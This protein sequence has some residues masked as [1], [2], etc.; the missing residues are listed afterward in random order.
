MFELVT[1]LLGERTS[2]PVHGFLLE[3]SRERDFPSDASTMAGLGFPVLTVTDTGPLRNPHHHAASDTP[4]RLDFDRLARLVAG[5]E[6][7]VREL[8]GGDAGLEPPSE[9]K[10]GAHR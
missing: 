5:L 1:R 8:G 3:P 4:D 10:A 9:R 6:E 7:L 2:L